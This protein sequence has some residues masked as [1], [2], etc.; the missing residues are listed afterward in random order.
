LLNRIEHHTF[1][2]IARIAEPVMPLHP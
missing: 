2:R 1:G